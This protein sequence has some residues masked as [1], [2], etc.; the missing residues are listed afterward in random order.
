[1]GLV[2]LGSATVIFAL[3]TKL[4]LLLVARALQ[5]LS[6]AIV[7]TVG[8]ALVFDKVGPSQLGQAM[9]YTSMSL[10]LGW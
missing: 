6:T 4:W 9:G 7:I 5:G 10:S 8:F 2:A 1:M 3:S